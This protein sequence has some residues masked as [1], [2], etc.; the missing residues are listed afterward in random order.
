V[1]ASEKSHVEESIGRLI[2]D[3]VILGLFGAFP[4]EERQAMN[5]AVFQ[6]E[7]NFEEHRT[8]DVL[9]PYLQAEDVTTFLTNCWEQFTE[10]ICHKG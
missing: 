10:Q 9:L 3:L 5:L 4:M 2:R 8:W 1:T 6:D 7:T